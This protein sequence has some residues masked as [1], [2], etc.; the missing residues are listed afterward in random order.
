MEACCLGCPNDETDKIAQALKTVDPSE[1]QLGVCVAVPRTGWLHFDRRSRIMALQTRPLANREFG[2]TS[3]VVLG[4]FG[5]DSLTSRSSPRLST[6]PSTRSTTPAIWPRTS[7]LFATRG[8]RPSL[9]ERTPPSGLCS[10]T[11]SAAPQSQ[12]PLSQPTSACRT[13]RLRTPSIGSQRSGS[14]VRTHRQSGIGSGL[15]PMFWT[16]SISSWNAPVAGERCARYTTV[17]ADPVSRFQVE[18]ST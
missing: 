5:P 7:P 14:S 2:V 16:R 6:P 8:T 4:S 15:S 12:L 18:I 9:P 10:T 1:S 11:A 13:S 17:Y 3:S